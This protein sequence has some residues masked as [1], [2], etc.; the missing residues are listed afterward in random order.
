MKISNVLQAY[1]RYRIEKN[2]KGLVGCVNKWDLIESKTTADIKQFENSIRERLA[3]FRDFPIIFTSAV[4]KQRIFKVLETAKQVYEARSR[5]ISTSELNE[6]LL[7]IVK[8]QNP[9]P[10]VKG[11]WIKIKYITQLP[12]HYPQ[13]V[14][15][16]NLPQYI[17]DPYKRSLE[18]KLRSHF[19]FKGCVLQIF[20]RQK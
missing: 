4:T 3:P 17:R 12:T 13:F 2:R 18:N 14:F 20:L 15:F 8:E 9:P 7:P 6:M 1:F 10:S 16:C 11:K 5:R 19:D